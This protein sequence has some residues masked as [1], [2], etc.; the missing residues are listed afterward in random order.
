MVAERGSA[1][2]GDV[3]VDGEE[4][5]SMAEFTASKNLFD[6]LRRGFEAMEREKDKSEG[7]ESVTWAP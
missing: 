1:S 4:V 7:V 2:G 6:D 3:P 5:V